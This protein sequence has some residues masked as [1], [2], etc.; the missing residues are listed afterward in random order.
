MARQSVGVIIEARQ[1]GCVASERVRYGVV[2]AK[3]PMVV[4]RCRAGERVFLAS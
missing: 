2:L 4:E 1:A 3:A